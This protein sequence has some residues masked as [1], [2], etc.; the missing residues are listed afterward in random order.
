LFFRLA[1]QGR[2]P[3]P[4]KNIRNKSGGEAPPHS[5]PDGKTVQTKAAEKHRRTPNQTA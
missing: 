4:K 5:K 2:T 1:L 3:S